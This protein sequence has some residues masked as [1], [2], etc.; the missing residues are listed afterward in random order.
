MRYMPVQLDGTASTS[1]GLKARN[2]QMVQGR[3]TVQQGSGGPDHVSIQTS[4]FAMLD[5]L[6]ADLMLLATPFSTAS[7]HHEGLQSHL[8]WAD[9]TIHLQLRPTTTWKRPE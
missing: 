2:A 6:R 8:L 5:H 3:C 4:G 9:R 1:I 7:F